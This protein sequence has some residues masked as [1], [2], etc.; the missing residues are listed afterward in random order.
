[1]NLN[2]LR[3]AISSPDIDCDDL[4]LTKSIER[5]NFAIVKQDHLECLEP[6]KFLN[7]SIITFWM[8]W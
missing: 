7:D 2:K 1:M 5:N 3:D 4:L 8:Q 6:T